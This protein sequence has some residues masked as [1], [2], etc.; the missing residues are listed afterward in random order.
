MGLPTS[1]AKDLIPLLKV[2]RE[3][4]IRFVREV[5]HA[6]PDKWQAEALMNSIN[7][8][9][10]GR[11]HVAMKSCA[12]PGKT[13]EL[14]WLGWHRLLCFGGKGQHPKGLALSI[15]W[16]NLNRGLWTELAKWYAVS[17]LL[18]HLFD[19]TKEQIRSKDH[20]RTWHLSATGYAKS[21]DQ[22]A[23]GRTL[24]GLHCEY[25]FILMD[26]SGD[27]AP[28]IVRSAEQ[29]LTGCISGLLAT[30]GNTT[31]QNGMLFHVC[32]TLRGEWDVTTITG[33]PDRADRSS[34]V[35]IDWA[36]KQI[37]TYGRDNPWVMAFVLGEF[38][39][40][41]LN[42]L[43][44][45]EDVEAAMKR[46]PREDAYC[47]AEK[48]LGVDVARFGD[49][50][51]VIFPRQGI[52]AFSPVVMRVADTSQISAR[53]ATAHNVWGKDS[54]VDQIYIDDTGHWGHG[55]IDQLRTARFPASGVQ[56]HSTQCDPQYYNMR[57]QIWMRMAEWVKQGGALPN[58]PEL[59]G[60]LTAPTYSFKKGKFLLEDKDQI[61]TR[62]GKSPDLADAL[63]LT[64]SFPERP[65]I[66]ILPGLEKKANM[67]DLE[68]DVL[69]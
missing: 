45:I 20:P 56:F 10:N 21:A 15:S 53:V 14:A 41:G 16:D 12:G 36:R 3:D 9:R 13:C 52:A 44:S 27:I 49:D 48:R 34:R 37:E 42:T 32:S 62:I 8:I 2:W 18:Q 29:A 51:T 50:R 60:E 57:A 40:G 6:E 23:I 47:W 31:S 1:I 7:P 66:N 26:E 30:A 54:Q 64:F 17:P 11:G 67:C 35:D 33:D 65:K 24:S 4:P 19:F 58:I 68:Y 39:P 43:L 5:F 61:K 28:S 22:E 59:V 63:A 46:A 38:P 69:A 25:P 55:V